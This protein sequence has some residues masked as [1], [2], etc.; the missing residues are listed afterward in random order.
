LISDL[1]FVSDTLVRQKEKRL[2]VHFNL[3][4]TVERDLLK[5]FTAGRDA[6]K[7]NASG[8]SATVAMIKSI[9]ALRTEM[10]EGPTKEN[11]IVTSMPLQKLPERSLAIKA[12]ARPLHLTGFVTTN[13]SRGDSEPSPLYSRRRH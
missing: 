9:W 11:D 5:M 6:T 10:L 7:V 12:R 1:G 3:P 2:A 4:H 8:W 13:T